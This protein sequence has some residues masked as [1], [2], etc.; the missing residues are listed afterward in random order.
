MMMELVADTLVMT[1]ANRNQN[2]EVRR[3]WRTVKS[4]RAGSPPRAAGE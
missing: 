3:A 1:P 2:A 4:W